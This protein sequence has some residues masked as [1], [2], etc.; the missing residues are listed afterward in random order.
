MQEKKLTNQA[1]SRQ[2]KTN[3]ATSRHI[4]PK[5]ASCSPVLRTFAVAKVLPLGLTDKKRF[6]ARR[7]LKRTF[8][9]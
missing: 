5:R 9:S 6:I 2:N 7:S 1:V 3:H 8:A 4:A